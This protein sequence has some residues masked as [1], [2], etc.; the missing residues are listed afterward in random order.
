MRVYIKFHIRSCE[1]FGINLDWE[2]ST[3]YYLLQLDRM[4]HTRAAVRIVPLIFHHPIALRWVV[5]FNSIASAVRRICFVCIR[6]REF[7][8]LY[9]VGVNHRPVF[10]KILRII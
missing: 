4:F 10:C 3:G 5:V 2:P 9:A 7:D 6:S 8:E 1:R